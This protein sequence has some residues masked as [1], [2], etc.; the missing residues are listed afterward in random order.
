MYWL[1]TSFEVNPPHFDDWNMHAMR[2]G[3]EICPT[4]KTEHWH[5]AIQF[6]DYIRVKTVKNCFPKYNLQAR[7]GNQVEF[8]A[9]CMKDGEYVSCGKPIESAQGERGDLA[10]LLVTVDEGATFNSLMVTHA[11]TVWRYMPYTQL[12]V[13]NRDHKVAFEKR[14][15]KYDKPLRGW[16][17][18]LKTI[19]SGEVDD[20]SVY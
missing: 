17:S 13:Q 3:K 4:T 10:D 20:R 7:K 8:F 1:I 15:L 18:D 6:K 11:K 5:A 16:Q 2:Y 14:K 19:V 12:L 9:Y